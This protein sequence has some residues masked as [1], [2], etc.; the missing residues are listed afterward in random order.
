MINIVK[1]EYQKGR[2][3]MR[4]KFIW[5]FPVITLVIAFLLTA[6]MKNAYAES[7]WNWWYSML[8]PGMLA[9]FCY[10]SVVQERKT[11][12][13]NL[14]TLSTCRK[15]LVL[16]K[17]IYMSFVILATNIVILIGA[18]VGG[19]LLTTHVPVGGAAV[20][21]IILTITHLWEIP[22]FLFLSE[23][24]GMIINLLI[25]LFITVAGVFVSQTDKWYLLVSAIPMRILC[26]FIFVLPNGMPAKEGDP[27]L[28]MGTVAPG[29][30]ISIIW[31]VLVTVLYVN[32][33]D[34]REVG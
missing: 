34:K 15:K 22:V 24:F 19:L 29:I 1:A 16:G 8:L 23:R 25:C 32:W 6:G 11:K 10:L 13:Y 3:S 33:F 28:A 27:L 18:S 9:I 4:H 14:T 31:F 2:R 17:I 20:A 12:Y 30:C 5:M 26:P 21:V 7:V